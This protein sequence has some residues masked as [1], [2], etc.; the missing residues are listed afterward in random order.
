MRQFLW[1]SLCTA[2]ALPQASAL[3]VSPMLPPVTITGKKVRVGDPVPIMVS[4]NRNT[5]LPIKRGIRVERWEIRRWVPLSPT[6]SG[7]L[8]RRS[9]QTPPGKT[10]PKDSDC[11]MIPSHQRFDGQ[12][13]LGTHGHAQCACDK[14]VPVSPGLYRFVGEYCA[15]T[16]TFS[17]PLFEIHPKKDTRYSCAADY[18][19]RLSCE[20]GAVN[21]K[22]YAANRQRIQECKGGCNSK[23]TMTRCV[24]GICT[25]FRRGQ[26]D[27]SCTQKPTRLPSR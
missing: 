18:G 25:A 7:L 22:W 15:G 4:N 23:G 21:R 24:R 11:L 1:I 17:G 26:V 12:P 5:P 13:W 14:C 19:C 3:A 6:A 10:A 8:L 27:P 16:K 20:H 2:L 9:C